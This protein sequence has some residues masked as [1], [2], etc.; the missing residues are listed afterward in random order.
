MQVRGGADKDAVAEANGG[1]EPDRGD[2][3]DGDTGAKA[4]KA[5]LWVSRGTR[6]GVESSG[7]SG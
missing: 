4:G 6:D 1:V 7:S 5:P 2:R 3:D